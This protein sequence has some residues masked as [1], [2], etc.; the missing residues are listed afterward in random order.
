[1]AVRAKAMGFSIMI[2]FHYS[3]WWA[4]PGKQFTP[5]EWEG[6]EIDQ[7]AA[8][9]Y[10]FTH[11]V[12][13]DLL[14]KGV[15]PEWVQIGNEISNG[16][17]WPVGSTDNWDNLAA[18]IKEGYR[19]TKAIDSSIKVALH[20]DNGANHAGTARWFDNARSR[21]VQWDV[22]GLSYYPV[23]HGSLSD[24]DSNMDSISARYDKEVLIVETAY[25]WTSQNGDSHP[26]TYTSTGP[27]SY[28][29]SPEGQEQFLNDLVGRI[30]AVPNGRGKGLF[31]WEPEWIPV[32]GAGWKYGE[33][34]EWDNVTLFDFDGNAL[35]ALDAF[36]D[37]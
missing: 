21:G 4:D 19:A 37:W 18:L 2:D 25:P 14:S 15:V 33:G 9:L 36:L 7:L 34:D 8:S 31:Y 6:Q 35:P 20:Y 16:M 1:L 13:S 30:K 10:R 29:M 28:R 17:I 12:L 27:V 11:D 32:E 26:N 5:H 24:L 3:D 23:W 22:I